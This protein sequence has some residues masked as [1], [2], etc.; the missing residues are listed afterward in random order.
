L[1]NQNHIALRIKFPE[2]NYLLIRSIIDDLEIDCFEEGE[3]ITN[4]HGDLELIHEFSLVTLRFS[5]EDSCKNALLKIQTALPE[6]IYEITRDNPNYLDEWKK[7]ATPIE[8]TDSITIHPSWLQTAPAESNKKIILLDAGY[9]FGSGSHETTMLCA[10]AIEKVTLKNKIRSMLDVGCGSGILS[11]I[12][13]LNGIKEVYGVDIDEDAVKAAIS[14]AEKNSL[15]E[16]NFSAKALSDIENRYDLV[17]ANI[18]SSV[19]FELKTD[20]LRCV[21]PGGT[22]ILSGL[23]SEESE[24]IIKE[25]ELKNYECS[26]LGEWGLIISCL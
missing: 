6:V 5:D 9:A 26:S 24:R 7:F 8:I 4:E 14:N 11:F 18:I 21:N 15:T 25:F 10:R 22:L 23:L 16:L 19:L 3:S 1:N 2:D 12:G 20:I 13:Y 17:V